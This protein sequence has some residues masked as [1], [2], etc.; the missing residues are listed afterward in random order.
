[1]QSIIFFFENSGYSS[2]E[3]FYGLRIGQMIINFITNIH[4]VTFQILMSVLQKHTTAVL[5]LCATI[6]RD[7]TTVHANLDILEMDGLAKVISLS[8]E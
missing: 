4:K 5:M 8:V 6:P 3:K 2:N 7:R 1:M